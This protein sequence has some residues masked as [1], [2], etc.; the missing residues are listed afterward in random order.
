MIKSKVI[1]DKTISLM[2]PSELKS[3]IE[4]TAQ[5]QGITFSEAIRQSLSNTY[6]NV[7]SDQ[8]AKVVFITK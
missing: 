8:K 3:K 1:K 5:K 6:G 2:I 7:E 4:H